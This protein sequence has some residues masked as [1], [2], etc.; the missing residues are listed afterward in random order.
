MLS[1]IVPCKNEQDAIAPF[2]QELIKHL[3][4]INTSY[5]LIFV[6]DGSTDNTLNEMIKVKK[7]NR[8]TKVLSFSRNFGKEAALLAGLEAAKGGYVVVMDVDLQDPPSLLK[9]M[10]KELQKGEY[11]C[12]GTRR[13]TRKGEP[14]IRSFFARCF[15]RLINKFIT[16]E[17]V[18]GARDYRMMT[19]K[20]VDAILSVKEYHR[21]SKGIFSW[22]GFKTKYIEYE[23]I[24][25]VNGETKWSFWALLKYAIE[26]IV[27]FSTF[28]LILP[29]LFSLLVFV[30]AIIYLIVSINIGFT[31]LS[32]I[33]LIISLFTCLVFLTI[34]FIG[35]YVGRTFVQSKNRPIYI[36]K[37]RY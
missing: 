36:I 27:S 7:H 23:N 2:Y 15:Y 24:E 5:E 20:M 37:D 3:K 12:I 28:V 32:I 1:V 10:Y 4:T 33:I 9:E 21:F 30:F 11:D 13:V 8:S 16:F 25:R 35:Q 14:P 29:F 19:R 31:D 26:G 18:D 6:D 34:G 17:I 22:V